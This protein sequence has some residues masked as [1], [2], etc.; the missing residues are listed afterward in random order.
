MKDR[1]LKNLLVFSPKIEDLTFLTLICLQ[2]EGKREKNG[3]NLRFAKIRHI[4]NYF[5]DCG[6]KIEGNFTDFLVGFWWLN[7]EK[8]LLCFWVRISDAFAVK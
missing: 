5:A 8:I 1:R 6:C 2:T 4:G 7:K 3:L